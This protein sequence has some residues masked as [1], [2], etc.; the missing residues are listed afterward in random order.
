MAQRSLATHRN[1]KY[2][3][4]DSTEVSSVDF[5]KVKETSAQTLRYNNAGTQTFVKFEGAPPSFLAGRKTLDRA[6]ILAVLNGKD[7]QNEG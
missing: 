4:I 2:L 3:I 6:Q 5:S 7:W 1:M